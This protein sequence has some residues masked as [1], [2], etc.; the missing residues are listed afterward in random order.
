MPNLK[1]AKKALRQSVKRGAQNK[2]VKDNL[3][4][5]RRSFRKLLESQK[6]EDAQKLMRDLGQALDKAAG[7]NLMKANTASRIKSRA[8]KKLNALAKK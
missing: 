5:M 6:L 3:A 7:K 1:N 2:M 4:F 8:A